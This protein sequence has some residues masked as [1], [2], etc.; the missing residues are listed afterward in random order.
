MAT[1]GSPVHCSGAMAIAG[2]SN[3]RPAFAGGQ[4]YQLRERSLLSKVQ[5]T[6]QLL[7][8]RCAGSPKSARSAST[9]PRAS[10]CTHTFRR[11]SSTAL[12]TS[13]CRCMISNLRSTGTRAAQAAA[14]ACIACS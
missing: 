11:A 5:C 4:L 10:P 12:A 14:A 7:R 3:R 6:R 13:Q 1:S 2:S 9:T 8:G